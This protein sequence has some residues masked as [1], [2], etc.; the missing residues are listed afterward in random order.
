MMVSGKSLFFAMVS[1]LVLSACGQPQAARSNVV[2]APAP[3]GELFV[4]PQTVEPL[5]G[6]TAA[7]SGPVKQADVYAPVITDPAQEARNYIRTMFLVWPGREPSA[8]E[9]ATYIALW[10]QGIPLNALSYQI[11]GMPEAKIR[12]YYLMI[13][14]REP[15]KA[16]LDFWVAQLKA[17][18]PLA[19]IEAAFRAA[20]GR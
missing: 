8:G 14:N 15:D 3:G 4:T 12:G 2:S 5:G 10:Q 17:G 19:D 16:G 18:M 13:L 20:V 11:A 9:M 1:V 6:G 7:V